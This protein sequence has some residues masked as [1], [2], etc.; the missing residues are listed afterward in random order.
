[1]K[2][3][4]KRKILFICFPLIFFTAFLIYLFYDG[5][6]DAKFRM[7]QDKIVSNEKV[8]LAGLRD[9]RASG[10]TAVCFADIKRNLSHIEGKKIIVDG[11]MAF[12]GYIKGI[13]TT[14]L[15][16]HVLT[17]GWRH[18]PRRLFLTGTFGER[19]DLVVSEEEEAKKYGFEYRKIP[20]GGKAIPSPQSVTDFIALCENLP[21][22]AWLHFHCNHGK[23]RTSIMLVMLDIMK[24]A[25]K[26]ALKDIVKR[27][28]LLGSS[29]LFDTEKWLYGTYTTSQLESRRKFIEDFYEFIVQRK[30][31]NT[32]QWSDWYRN[33]K[34]KMTAL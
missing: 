9:L 6:H 10:G 2:R 34:E 29:D 14:I 33:Q 23:G 3:P 1:M 30:A 21:E 11:V 15:G 28:H 13:P 27:Q 24:N 17:P 26:V 12:H 18:Y 32:Q 5:V 22:N 4:L 19:R 25:P 8:D 20:I 7:M 16:Y 31:G